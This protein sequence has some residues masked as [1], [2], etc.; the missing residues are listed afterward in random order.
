MQF[1]AQKTKLVCTIGPASESV[2]VLER[3]I[4]VGMNVARLNF[5]HGDFDS[6]RQVIENIRAASRSTGRMVA[7]MAD[8]PGPKIRVGELDRDAIELIDGEAPPVGLRVEDVVL[9]RRAL[10][11]EQRE[12]EASV[13]R[14]QLCEGAE[15]EARERV[16]PPV[17]AVEVRGELDRAHHGRGGAVDGRPADDLGRIHGGRRP[18]DGPGPDFVLTDGNTNEIP[19]GWSSAAS[20]WAAGWR[21]ISPRPATTICTIRRSPGECVPNGSTC[22]RRRYWTRTRICEGAAPRPAW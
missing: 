20:P 17:A 19:A 16:R 15:L 14:A 5:S 4:G 10:L 2:P 7:I 1:P 6:H 3:L 18:G 11:E 22:T 9:S 13:T 21:R 8:L 12:E